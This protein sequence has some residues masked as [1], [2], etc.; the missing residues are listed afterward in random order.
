MQ[1]EYALQDK[2]HQMNPGGYPAAGRG[3]LLALHIEGAGNPIVL[4][5]PV[6]LQEGLDGGNSRE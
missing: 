1:N 6:M 3:A 2:L 4:S 5:F